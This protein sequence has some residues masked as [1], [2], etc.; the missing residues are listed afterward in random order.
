MVPPTPTR[1]HADTPTVD[2]RLPTRH[3]DREDGAH[4]LHRPSSHT[5]RILITIAI[6]LTCT[7]AFENMGTAASRENYDV[8]SDLRILGSPEALPENKTVAFERLRS[9][10]V[11]EITAKDLL[12]ACAA[13]EEQRFPLWPKP[14]EGCS[15]LPPSRLADRVR[16][17]V[18]G[19][20]LGDSMGLAT[21]FLSKK[22]AAAF[23][24]EDFD[25]CP[26]P[27]KTYPDTHRLMWRAG[28]WTDDTDQLVLVM[29]SL[30]Q[31]IGA[32]DDDDES[33]GTERDFA[34][35][36]TTWAKSGFAELGDESGAGVGRQTKAALNKQDFTDDP[37]RASRDVWEASGR[38]SAANGAVMRT[39]IT[40]VPLFW[41]MD[42]CAGLT[43]I[44]CRTTHADPRCVAS[45]TFVAACVALLLQGIDEG[46]REEAAG[47]GGTDAIMDAALAAAVKET[48]RYCSSDLGM[49]SAP[50]IAELRSFLTK[51]R[52]ADDDISRLDVGERAR[53][54]YTHKCLSAGVWDLQ[55]EEGF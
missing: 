13:V 50:C 55:S 21:E 1:R 23:Y 53:I 47:A 10:F 24:G 54:G 14:P 4:R 32:P 11:R 35:R 20:A 17:L 22:D 48:E 31:C 7:L 34:R 30:L 33:R 28:D 5:E 49:D 46:D 38:T 39:A 12:E 27:S 41:D 29:Q 19:C 44:M 52:G 6:S 2:C 9:H 45:C 51:A 16:G 8:S 26:R 36:M 25:Y 37:L 3:E 40:G 42:R 18:F 15:R 43:S